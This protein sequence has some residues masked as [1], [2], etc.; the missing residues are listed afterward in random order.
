MASD[1]SNKKSEKEPKQKDKNTE[2]K[3][4]WIEKINKVF[5]ELGE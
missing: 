4:S 2:Q 5:K 1:K 3:S